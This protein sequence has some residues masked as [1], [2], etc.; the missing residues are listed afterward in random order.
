MTGSRTSPTTLATMTILPSEK[1]L[2]SSGLGASRPRP[3]IV[4]SVDGKRSFVTT[5]VVSCCQRHEFLY[6]SPGPS[7]H[8]KWQAS[9]GSIGG[10][11][12]TVP[13]LWLVPSRLSINEKDALSREARGA[14]HPSRFPQSRVS[15][16]SSIPRARLSRLARRDDWGRVRPHL[17]KGTLLRKNN[18]IS[19]TWFPSDF[20]SLKC[21]HTYN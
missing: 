3:M 10:R 21:P 2:Q 12:N 6:F 19:F 11:K 9:Q 18:E 4:L 8:S 7:R 1:V 15:R 17:V 20:I 5:T 14:H 16:S 13:Q